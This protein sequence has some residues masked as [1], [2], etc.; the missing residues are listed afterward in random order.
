ME[1]TPWTRRVGVLGNVAASMMRV[2]TESG[3]VIAIRSRW[4]WPAVVFSV[5]SKGSGALATG[6]GIAGNERR[7]VT[8]RM[9][10]VGR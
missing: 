6:R 5:C 3:S 9:I 4:P 10:R 2:W 1:S 7:S 8:R